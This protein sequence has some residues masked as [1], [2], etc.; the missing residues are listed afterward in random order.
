[1]LQERKGRKQKKQKPAHL[2]DGYGIHIE[3]IVRHHQEIVFFG[4]GAPAGRVG[5]QPLEQ[6]P[7]GPCSRKK[8]KEYMFLLV[9]KF[10]V[11]L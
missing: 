11:F 8:I 6:P 5:G 10:I 2:V 9:R 4:N 3:I 7:L 1:L